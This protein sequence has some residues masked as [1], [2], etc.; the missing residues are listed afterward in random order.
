MVNFVAFSEIYLY[1]L[2]LTCQLTIFLLW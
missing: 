1:P 2:L